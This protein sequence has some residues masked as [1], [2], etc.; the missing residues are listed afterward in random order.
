MRQILMNPFIRSPFVPTTSNFWQSFCTLRNSFMFKCWTVD[1]AL[2]SGSFPRPRGRFFVLL[3]YSLLTSWICLGLWSLCWH[4]Q[5][6]RRVHN[7]DWGWDSHTVFPSRSTSLL[8]ISLMTQIAKFMGPI[9]GP[10]GSY[11]P[12]MVPI[13]A[14]RTLLSGDFIFRVIRGI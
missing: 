11:Q 9:W 7:T 4:R 13:L 5:L 2:I 14:P 6:L 10:P 3:R 12:Q 8:V 1:F